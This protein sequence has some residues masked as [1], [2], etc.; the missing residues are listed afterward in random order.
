M[1]AA[2][3]PTWAGTQTCSG[4][5]GTPTARLHHPGGA[6]DLRLH[7]VTVPGAVRQATIIIEDSGRATVLNEPGP[8]VGAHDAARIL[9]RAD[10]LMAGRRLVAC[11]GSL[12]PGLPTD[13]YGRLCRTAR[14]LGALVSSTPRGPRWPR[15]WPRSRTWSPPT[16]PRPRASTASVVESSHAED[17]RRVRDRASAPPGRWRPRRPP[18]R[19]HRRRPRRGLRRTRR[20]LWCDAPRVAVNPIG[21]GDALVGGVS[22]RSDGGAGWRDAVRRGGWWPAPRSSTRTPATSTRPGSPSWSPRAGRLMRQPTLHDVAA[23]AGV[24]GKSVSR[25]V[26]GAANVAPTCASGSSGRREAQL[27]AEHAGPDTEG[28][29]RRHHRRGHRHHRGPVLRR[30][31]QRGRGGAPS[32][33]GWAPSSAAPASTP[34]ASASR[35]SGWPCSRSAALILAPVPGSHDY[36]RRYARG[37]PDRDGRPGGRGAGLRHRAGRRRR[38]WPDRAV[39]H[40]CAH[41]HRRI[42]FVGSDE[43][44]ATARDRLAGY[45]RGAGRDRRRAAARPASARR[46]PATWTQ[47]AVPTALLALPDPP[48][49]VFAAN[50]RAGIGVAHAL[51]TGD[52]ADLAFISFGDF[53]LA[54]SLRPPVTVR[55]PGPAGDRPGGHA[56]A[57]G[58]PGRRARAGPRTSSWPRCCCRAGS[59]E[60]E[61]AS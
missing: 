60:I 26:N 59:G 4:W 19:G 45:R 42:A 56:E 37:V 18:G 55:R 5:S 30:P 54:Q 57:A 44:F 6:E 48:T 17:R 31:D 51:H 15:R 29:H 47:A 43:R 36:L 25:V 35:S 49:A 39:A 16:W 23:E 22:D 41:G 28:G 33:P 50:P 38:R 12:P 8:L 27:R 61:V 46:R 24:S 2:R 11:V 13:T 9:D 14:E 53:P 58:G 7:A 10:A 1:S 3:S 21:A 40:L 32:E 52:R 34:N 20:R